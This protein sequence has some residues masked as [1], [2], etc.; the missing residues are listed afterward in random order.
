MS[1]V[2]T[3]SALFGCGGS[4]KYTVDDIISFHTSYYGMASNPVYAF[5]LRKQDE[6]WLFS[7]SCWV[8]SREDYYTS[9]SSF[10]I[11]TEEAEKFLEIIREEDEIRRL[12]KYRNPIRFFHIADEPMRSSRMTFTDGNSI[13]KETKLCDRAIDCLRDLADRHYEAAE[14]AELIAIKNKL[15]SVFIRLK[16]IEPWRSHSFTLKKDGDHWYFS[17]ECSFGEDSLPVKAENVRLSDEETDDVIRII[18]KSDLISKASEYAEPPEDID[19]ITDR[20]VYITEFSLAD[21]SGINSTFPA[22]DELTGCLYG[23]AG[24][25]LLTEVNISR[26]C[27]DHSSSYSFSLEKAEDNWFLSFDCATDRKGYHTNAEKLPVNAEEAEEILRIVRDQRLISEVLSY[28]EP[29]E[30]DIYALDETTYNTSFVLS[31]GSSVHAPINAGS[32]LSDAFF[33][34][35]GRINKKQTD[36]VGK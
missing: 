10:P 13:E 29:P 28:E 31:D 24:A 33:S 4:G 27:M 7:A 9:F 36:S 18:A 21:G 23:L 34:L 3:V 30:S 35:A 17:F 26:S 6:N 1:V 8:E 19:S 15:T 25:K 14:K 32:E 11:P 22:P 2:L 16:D 5:V 20:N 12:R